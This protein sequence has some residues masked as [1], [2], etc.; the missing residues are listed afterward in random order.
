MYEFGTFRLIPAS[1]LLL[2]KGH[3]VHLTPKVFDVLVLL[4]ERSALEGGRVLEKDELMSALWPD[5]VVEESNLSQNVF[6]LRKALG[7]QGN[8]NRYIVTVPGRGY[9]FVAAVRQCPAAEQ[10]TAH[11]FQVPGR[12]AAVAI[13][14]LAVGIAGVYVRTRRA[15]RADRGA[16]MVARRLFAGDEVAWPGSASRDG[17]YLT[18]TAWGEKA[19]RALVI[20]EVATGRIRI[21]KDDPGH[22]TVV[23]AARFS[24]DG[25][26][27]AYILD[28]AWDKTAYLHFV[29]ADGLTEPWAVYE[30]EEVDVLGPLDWSPD[31]KFIAAVL[32]RRNENTFQIALFEARNGSTRMLKTLHDNPDGPRAAPRP[33]FS[34]DGRYV[35]YQYPPQEGAKTDIFVLTVES[36]AEVPLVVDPAND[37]L[38]LWADDGRLIFASDRTGTR[39]AWSIAVGNGKAAG[40]P[41]LVRKDLGTG[42]PLGLTGNGSYFYQV[43]QTSR[44]VYLVHLDPATGRVLAGPTPVDERYAGENSAPDWSPDGRSLAYLRRGHVKIRDIETGEEREITAALPKSA[45]DLRWSPDGSLTLFGDETPRDHN[46]YRLDVENGKVR[47]LVERNLGNDAGMNPTWSPDGKLLYKADNAAPAAPTPRK[48]YEWDPVKREEKVFFQGFQFGSWA[49]SPSGRQV[50]FALYDGRADVVAVVAAA[51]GARR[52]V[53]RTSPETFVPKFAGLAWTRDEKALL[54]PVVKQAGRETEVWRFPLDG[55]SPRALFATGT[56]SQ[57][58]VSPDGKRLAVG[59]ARSG[60]E[61]WVMENFLPP[62]KQRAP[63]GHAAR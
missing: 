6:S 19:D 20:R 27:I 8:E 40:A 26:L 1:R 7:Q 33:S 23:R 42:L 46:L 5:T 50:A 61:V 51:G 39:D 62:L 31:G 3:A 56:V 13:L 30:S 52:V 17:R 57:L 16:R 36:R 28:R 14:A 4:V 9:A 47:R 41:E 2:C 44:D 35:A 60:Q 29:S 11:R 22:N 32:H 55:E 38:L 12:V 58:R 18:Y 37:Q 10:A 59:S 21:L 34:P 43:N 48:I 63:A 15:D 45:S 54:V 25:K 53:F 24:R 49:L